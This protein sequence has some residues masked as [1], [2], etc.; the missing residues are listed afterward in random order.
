MKQQS[1]INQN[2][3]KY[4]NCDFANFYSQNNYLSFLSKQFE[5]LEYMINWNKIPMSITLAI[6][7]KLSEDKIYI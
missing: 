6:L 7:L 2:A 3:I 1:T 5:I 4:I